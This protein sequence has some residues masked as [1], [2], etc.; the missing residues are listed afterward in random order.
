MPPIVGLAPRARSALVLPRVPTA[1]VLLQMSPGCARCVDPHSC[2]AAG[3]EALH[4][5][6][7]TVLR[8]CKAKLSPLGVCLDDLEE[9]RFDVQPFA[10]SDFAN[11][12]HEHL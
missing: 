12:V 6:G 2:L 9:A 10:A 8:H 7:D 3:L 4:D 5:K 11:G 1:V